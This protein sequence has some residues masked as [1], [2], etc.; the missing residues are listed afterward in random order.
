MSSTTTPLPPP[1]VPP[2]VEA[3]AS[4]QGVTAYLPAV[5]AMT[6]RIFPSAPMKVLVEDD[7]EIA[8]DRHIVVE[9]EL[10]N[11]PAEQ[12]AEA[13]WAWCG[14]IFRHCPPTHV[15]VFRLGMVPAP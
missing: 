10:A 6:R 15:H 14:E 12:M 3:F 13:Q 9:V 8:N 11:M 4:E 5:L 7:P 2:E 1:A